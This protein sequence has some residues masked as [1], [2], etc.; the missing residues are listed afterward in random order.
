MT[1]TGN[2]ILIALAVCILLFSLSPSR[3]AEIKTF[4]M[5]GGQKAISIVGP[6]KPSDFL[7][8]QQA[9]YGL[10]VDYKDIVVSL[11]SPGGNVEGIAIG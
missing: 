11:D 10:A 7:K 5:P 4:E 9:A 1:H 3:A 2:V 8:F 6:I